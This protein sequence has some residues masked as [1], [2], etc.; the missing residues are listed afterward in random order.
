MKQRITF[1][2]WTDYCFAYNLWCKIQMVFRIMELWGSNGWSQWVH[3]LRHGSAVAHLLG[4]QVQILPGT[5]MSV[6]CEC[7]GLPGTRSAMG[8]RNLRIQLKCNGAWWCTRGEVKGKLVNGVGSRYPSH[9]LGTWCIQH[10]YHCCAQLGCQQSTEL[11]PLL[12]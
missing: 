1:A 7:C 8:Q 2:V 11:T 9:C 3:G 12:I 6:S 10:Y 4:L 5:W